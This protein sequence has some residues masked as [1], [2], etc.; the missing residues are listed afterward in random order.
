MILLIVAGYI[1]SCY[2]WGAWRRWGDFYSTILY[3]IIG[4]LAYQFVFRNYK[5]WTYTGLLGH[6]YT[7]LIITFIVFPPAIILYLTHFP[8]GF[9]KQA[10]YVVAWAI[11]N[12]LIE[13]AS[14]I[15]NGL[16]YEH[17]WCLLWSFVLFGI[18][19]ILIRLHYKKPL[20]VW[21]ISL[22]CGAACSIIFGLPPLE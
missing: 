8:S 11:V 19:F 10:L 1:T 2:K 20:L 7:S 22:A 12:T 3:V 14:C 17:N 18:A 9:F 6:T 21:P 13:L 4:D 16:L 5:L 15:T